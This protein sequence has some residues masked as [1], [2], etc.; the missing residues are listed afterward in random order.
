MRLLAS[1][2]TH[3]SIT[4]NYA[5]LESCF[6]SSYLCSPMEPRSC[7]NFRFLD[8]PLEVQRLILGKFYEEQWVITGVL[9]YN[10]PR[11]LYEL[12]FDYVSPLYVSRHFW[13]ETR[14]A[15]RNSRSGYYQGV[16]SRNGAEVD[17]SRQSAIFD[18]A[19]TTIDVNPRRLHTLPDL[20]RQFP[21]LETANLTGDLNVKFPETRIYLNARTLLDIL[22]GKVDSSIK[23]IARQDFNRGVVPTH[24][25]KRRDKISRRGFDFRWCKVS[26]SCEVYVFKNILLHHAEVGSRQR[27]SVHLQLELTDQDCRI[28]RRWVEDPVSGST[29]ENIDPL[30]E[31]LSARS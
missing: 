29:M 26:M 22:L 13:H 19:V 3:H 23:A 24:V 5:P 14:R 31:D 18:E 8:L 21:N 27:C 1:N 16:I 2:V 17:F 30:I 7:Q 4:I 11:L 10:K 25:P 9:T 28:S 15:I 12:Q 20:K 6:H